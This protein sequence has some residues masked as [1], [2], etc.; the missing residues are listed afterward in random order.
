MSLFAYVR[1]SS[2]AGTK[3]K[4]ILLACIRECLQA[5]MMLPICANVTDPAPV[6]GSNQYGCDLELL[7]PW[8]LP[9][10]SWAPWHGAMWQGRPKG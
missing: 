9:A 5:I 10:A 8:P 6:C 1:E 4:L 7:Q 2:A 3:P